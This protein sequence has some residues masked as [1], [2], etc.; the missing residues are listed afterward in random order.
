MFQ[1]ASAFNQQLCWDLTGKT[2]TDMFT[3]TD[4][5]SAII[6]IPSSEPTSQPTG[7]PT[8][9]PTIDISFKKHF[10]DEVEGVA[11]NIKKSLFQINSGTRN[12][13]KSFKRAIQPPGYK[14]D[15]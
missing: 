12:F 1:N 8:S 2:T 7:Q 15:L 6:C 9:Q 11:S 5:A 10:K 13:I 4:G 14:E 3:G